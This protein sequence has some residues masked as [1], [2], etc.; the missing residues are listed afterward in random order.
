MAI[1]SLTSRPNLANSDVHCLRTT[2]ASMSSVSA[3]SLCRRCGSLSAAKAM[4]SDT[5]PAAAPTTLD[6]LSASPREKPPVS[7][8]AVLATTR[9]PPVTATSHNDRFIPS[10]WQES[11]AARAFFRNWPAGVRQGND[12]DIGASSWPP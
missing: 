9:A 7:R 11:A 5:T 12:D 2:F 4:A 3:V 10:C 1:G 6:T 8:Y